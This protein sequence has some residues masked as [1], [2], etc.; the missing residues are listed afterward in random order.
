[1]RGQGYR[2]T[3]S[4]GAGLPTNRERGDMVADR[5]RLRG[6]GYRQT[7]SE[8]AGLPTNRE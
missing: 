2:Q 5:Q 6:Q 3:E 4:E 8:G 1:M 7:E